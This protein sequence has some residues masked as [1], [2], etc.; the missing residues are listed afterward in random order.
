M[1]M[2]MGEDELST[3]TVAELKVRLKKLDLPVSGKKADLLSRLEGAMSSESVSSDDEVLILEDDGDALLVE[4]FEEVS[5]DDDDD[6]FDAEVIVD[7]D[8]SDVFEAEILEA[9][10]PDESTELSRSKPVRVK[11]SSPWYK[12]GTNIAT[13]IVV[14][15][16]VAGGG[17]WYLTQQEVV[18]RAAPS[19]YGDTFEFEVKDGSVEIV[20]DEMIKY[21]RDQMP[22][23]S[24]GYPCERVTVDF[25]G[26]GK[27]AITEGTLSDLVNPSDKDIQGAVKMK[28]GYGRDWNTVEQTLTYDLSADIRGNTQV[29]DFCS[30]NTEFNRLN[31]DIEISMSTWTEISERRLLR[32]Q[33]SLDFSDSDG[34]HTGTDTTTFGS[35][36]N[37]ET[38]MD[39]IDVILLPM[40]PVSIYDMFQ[41]SILSEGMT[42][43]YDGWD[44]TVGGD[45]TSG[46]EDAIL[47]YMEH[48]ET[49]QCLGNAAVTLWVVPD[50]PWPSAQQVDI[51][52][53]GKGNGECS[54]GTEAA[55][56][57]AYPEGE[58]VRI[59]YT[60]QE[61]NFVRG[62][63]RLDWNEPYSFMPQPGEGIPGEDQLRPWKSSTHMWDDPGNNSTSTRTYSIEEAVACVK[64]DAGQFGDANSALTSDGYVFAAID[65]RTGSDP[66]WNL[67]W[68]SSAGAGWVK[69]R[70]HGGE[71]CS[72]QGD[73]P[74]FGDDKPEFDRTK[75][76]DTLELHTL[77]SR[78]TSADLYPIL[79]PQITSSNALRDDTDLG[80]SLVIPEKNAL[81]DLLPDDFLSGKVTVYVDRS[82]SEGGNDLTFQAGMDAENARMIGWTL[83]STSSE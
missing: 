6:L 74:I 56:E 3:L 13:A 9:E 47:V 15:L 1:R 52:L 21:I 31:N 63:D 4:D 33:T 29:E 82:W 30:S 65:D 53:N 11:S 8:E 43:Q 28:D 80:Y 24:L 10:L 61:S 72:F 41:T 16:I 78:I 58:T 73:G 32:S 49:K 55:I 69:V 26:N 22:S 42:G 51:L 46:G 54:L 20:G 50:R 60:L 2:A 23:D 83:T 35:I 36:A 44:W 48:L 7:E 18:F 27:A 62:S 76:P 25:A 5:S 66:E 57:F 38:L 70:S 79:H 39:A 71:S 77:E 68:I 67:S 45:A 37:S 12:D 14:L 81:T 34:K 75:I 59:R 19:H 64:A 17:W 40:H